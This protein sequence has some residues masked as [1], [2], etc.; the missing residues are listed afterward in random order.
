MSILV[1]QFRFPFYEAFIWIGLFRLLLG[2]LRIEGFLG[3]FYYP[4]GR[5]ASEEYTFGMME[6]GYGS[7]FFYP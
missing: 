5:L 2:S 7:S 6:S 3:P 4:L 1:T